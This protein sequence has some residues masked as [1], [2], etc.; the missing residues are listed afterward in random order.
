[1][2]VLPSLLHTCRL[3]G[4]WHEHER[5][6]MVRYAV[7]H[8]AHADC[9]LKKWGAKFFDRLHLWQLEN[10]PALIANRH[11]LYEE[12]GKRIKDRRSKK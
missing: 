6:P 3:C 9:A 8:W 11:G 7:R 2:S 1:V 10:F 5:G 4:D 12:L